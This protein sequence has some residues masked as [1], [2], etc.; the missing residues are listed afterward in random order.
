MDSKCEQCGKEYKQKQPNQKFCGKACSN[1]W[2][3]PGREHGIKA[4]LRGGYA[5][6]TACTNLIR[7][8]YDVYRA[9]CDHGPCDLVA[10]KDG[11]AT[12]F[13][14]TSG[15]IGRRSGKIAYVRHER[16]A[17]KFDAFAVVLPDDSVRYFNGAGDSIEP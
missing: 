7:R 15:T 8:G 9:V 5:E 17:G 6:L 4:S 13:E 16:H 11:R 3:K 14:V 12:R 10:I 1:E 2:H